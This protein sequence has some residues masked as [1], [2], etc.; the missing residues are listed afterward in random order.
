MIGKT[1]S[2]GS[3]TREDVARVAAALLARDDTKGWYDLLQGEDEVDA[4]VEKLV[5]EGWDGIE[6]EDLNRIYAKA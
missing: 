3:V 1:P 5:K 4:A 6:G 2:R